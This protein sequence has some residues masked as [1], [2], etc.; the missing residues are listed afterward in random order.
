MTKA[1][2]AAQLT[3]NVELLTMKAAEG[4][5][6]SFPVARNAVNHLEQF[7]ETE[8]E[9]IR[10]KEAPGRDAVSSE[11]KSFSEGVKIDILKATADIFEKNKVYGKD[12]ESKLLLTKFME[13][14]ETYLTENE[15]VLQGRII[16]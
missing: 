13:G 4:N 10:V 9:I 8:V 2:T 16:V 6:K 3:V 1:D 14:L 7:E 15:P 12:K 11:Q 5:K